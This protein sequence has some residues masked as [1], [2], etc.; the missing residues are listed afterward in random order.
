MRSFGAL[1]LA[2]FISVFVAGIVQNQIA[3]V[4]GAREEFIAVMMLFI[5]TAIVAILAFGLALAIARSVRGID[6][7]ALALL[8]LV[9]L[10]LLGAGPDHKIT[11][12]ADDIPILAEIAA[13]T[14]LM[15][16]I[17]WWLVRRRWRKR[18]A[19]R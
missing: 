5:A 1:L 4:Y 2:F 19:A 7:T 11:V 8:I 16:G 3:I 12:S 14:A 10:A 6:W 15:I 17:Q 13:P 18:H 9:W